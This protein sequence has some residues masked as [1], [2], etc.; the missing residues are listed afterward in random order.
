MLLICLAM[1]YAF[2]ALMLLVWQ[3]EGHLAC[4]NRGGVLAWLS[5][6]SKVQTCIWPSRCHCH[7]LSLASVKSR[8][9]LPFWYRL[10][11]V[12]SDKGPLNGCASV[13]VVLQ[14]C[15]LLNL[16]KHQPIPFALI[17]AEMLLKSKQWTD[18]IFFHFV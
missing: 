9:G 12:V 17:L 8:L 5:V 6:W 18:T 4:R 2:S 11:Q 15:K 16:Y 3:Q 10:T 7:S 14:T 13:C 1:T